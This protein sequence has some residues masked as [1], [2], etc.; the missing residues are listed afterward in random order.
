M[1]HNQMQ[2][3]GTALVWL[4]LQEWVKLAGPIQRHQF[5]TTANVA[6]ADPDLRHAVHA[7]G[8]LTHFRP[9]FWAKR[10]VDFVKCGALFAKQGFGATAKR[11]HH[12]GVN[13]DSG[14]GERPYD[15]DTARAV[16]RK[17][18]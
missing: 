6:L 1:G 4:G 14:H 13:G 3:D 17:C 8:F 10:D 18:R 12:R 11:A 2:P 16:G 15:D 9:C 7:A 5:V